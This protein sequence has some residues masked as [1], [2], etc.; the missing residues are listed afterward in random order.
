MAT[1]IWYREH[2]PTLFING[3]V[4]PA[5]ARCL[6]A[7]GLR[8]T[9][10]HGDAA[11]VACRPNVGKPNREVLVLIWDNGGEI[12]VQVVNDHGLPAMIPSRGSAPLSRALLAERIRQVLDG[13]DIDYNTEPNLEIEDAIMA[14]HSMDP[15]GARR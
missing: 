5:F 14:G 3:T 2:E 6:E 13:E 12:G 8:V 15:A 7:F 9:G 1:R 10:R 4:E 11:I